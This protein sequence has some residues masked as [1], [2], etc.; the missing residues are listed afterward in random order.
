MNYILLIAVGLCVVPC[1]WMMI[2]GHDDHK[3]D[4]SKGKK[5]CCH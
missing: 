4:D 5:G 1:I 2:K 3:D